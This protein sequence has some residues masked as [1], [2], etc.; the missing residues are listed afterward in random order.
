YGIPCEASAHSR[1]T[2]SGQA[3]YWFNGL[4][5]GVPPQDMISYLCQKKMR[6]EL[7]ELL[8]SSSS[9]GFSE[10]AASAVA[11]KA[12]AAIVDKAVA[13]GDGPDKDYWEGG[14][15]VEFIFEGE[16]GVREIVADGGAIVGE[17][18]PRC[19]SHEVRVMMRS[20]PYHL[21]SIHLPPQL[22]KDKDPLIRDE[23]SFPSGVKGTKSPT[24][25][26][27]EFLEQTNILKIREE[28]MSPEYAIKGMI[29]TKSD[30]FSFEVIALKLLS[31]IRSQ[32]IYES[33]PHL[34]L[35]SLA[36]K[37]WQEGNCLQ[38]LD[39]MVANSS[40]ESELSRCMEVGLL[41]VQ[42]H[43]RDRPTMYEVVTMLSSDSSSLPRPKKPGFLV[44]RSPTS[45]SRNQE[46]F[47]T[48]ELT[49]TSI[50]EG[51]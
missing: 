42:E 31:G 49:N 38:L 10:A 1:E 17:I 3:R 13:V 46:S 33:K 20:N 50:L 35:L 37:L 24:L 51:R 39:H 47:T 9:S 14:L 32:G 5:R 26:L 22:V 2:D 43:A 12:V 45:S 25:E 19:Y 15:Y 48:N 4:E 16:E 41:C 34:N 44:F 8:P 28:Y 21:P 36:W 23:I 6:P 27:Q 18:S 11:D 30:V 7:S 29:S 40:H